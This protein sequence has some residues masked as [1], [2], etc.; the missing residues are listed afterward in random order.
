MPESKRLDVSESMEGLPECHKLVGLSE[1]HKL[2]GFS[3]NHNLEGLS[4]SRNLEVGSGIHE[5]MT[6][7]RLVDVPWLSSP[8]RRLWADINDDDDAW[9]LAS[10]VS[11]WQTASAIAVTTAERELVPVYVPGVGGLAFN[12]QLD[13][14][15]FAA[16]LDA[17][18]TCG[19]SAQRFIFSGKQ[20]ASGQSLAS[21]GIKRNSNLFMVAHLRGGGARKATEEEKEIW[22]SPSSE[23][24]ELACVES[25]KEQFMQEQDGWGLCR[26]CSHRSSRPRYGESSYHFSTDAHKNAVKWAEQGLSDLLGHCCASSSSRS[27]ASS[28]AS[29]TEL[30]PG[31]R[32]RGVKVSVPTEYDFK[33]DGLPD[34]AFLVDSFA[35]MVSSDCELGRA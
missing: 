15:M 9:D 20:L 18:F 5:P 12:L 31:C 22:G 2:E 33:R 29:V 30:V 25:G 35:S 23:T 34:G 8:T 19:A 11:A 28:V 17:K 10:C 27:S 24:L 13:I 21:Y 6:C 14:S 1:C 3:E 7:V 16:Q 26:V 4:E 32:P